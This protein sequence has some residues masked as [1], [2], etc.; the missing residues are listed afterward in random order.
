M[1]RREHKHMLVWLILP[2][3]A[4][5][6]GAVRDLTYG[7]GMPQDLAHSLSIFPL[8]GMILAIAI[9][10]ARRWPLD[11][12]GAA[13][14]GAGWFLLTIVFEFALGAALRV[15]LRELLAAYDVTRG[16]LWVFVPLATAA[17]PTLARVWQMRR[18]TYHRA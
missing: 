18:P 17:A 12:R 4:V 9:L 6:N 1:S 2:L 16:R 10:A 5:A 3:L 14:V 15:P 11:A 7:R 13:R 8:V